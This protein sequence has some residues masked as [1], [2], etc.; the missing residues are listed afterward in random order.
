MPPRQRYLAGRNA[1]RQCGH[2]SDAF[3]KRHGLTIKLKECGFGYL[4][5]ILLTS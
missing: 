2:H 4:C 3:P 5:G 1:G